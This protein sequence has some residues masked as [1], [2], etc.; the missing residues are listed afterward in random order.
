MKLTSDIYNQNGEKVGEIELPEKVFNVKMN[1]DLLHQAVRYYQALSREPIAKT[2]TRA[3]VRGGGRKPWRQKGTGRARHGSIR[4]PIWKGGGVVFGPTTEKK[5][6]LKFPKKMRKKALYITLSQKLE[7]K[8]IIFLDK[9]EFSE[10]KTRNAVEFLN[11][12]SK[13]KK[14]IKKKKKVLILLR[15]NEN[16]L[17]T[18]RNISSFATIPSGSLNPYFLLKNKYL[19]ME[20]EV[21]EKLK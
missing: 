2:K 9:I 21:V 10:G 13:I 19:I 18:I 12:L 4:S 1:M 8:E 16:I 15:K 3:E 20:K 11:N 14:D 7:D 6:K 5:Y 17:R